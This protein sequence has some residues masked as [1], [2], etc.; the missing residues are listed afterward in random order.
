M[1]SVKKRASREQSQTRLVSAKAQPI[2]LKFCGLF[3]G[4][5]AWPCSITMPANF[6]PE[7]VIHPA[8]AGAMSQI[9]IIM[10]AS[11]INSSPDM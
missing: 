3:R 5:C 8:T 6:A 7:K 1:R 9:K 4:N 10:A 2:L 11:H